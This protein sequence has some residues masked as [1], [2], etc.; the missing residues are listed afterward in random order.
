MNEEWT[1]RLH[2]D[3]IPSSH[4]SYRRKESKG[5]GPTLVMKGLLQGLLVV[6]FQSEIHSII[7]EL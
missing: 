2:F 1:V 4:I 5:K 3:S 6:E 7:T